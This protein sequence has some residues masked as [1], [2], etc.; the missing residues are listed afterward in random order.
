MADGDQSDGEVVTILSGDTYRVAFSSGPR[1]GTTWVVRDA[2]IDT[3]E[4]TGA[5]G[6]EGQGAVVRVQELIAPDARQVRVTEKGLDQ[7]GRIVAQVE[8][9]PSG[10]NI[11]VVLK[12]EGWG[13]GSDDTI[14]GDT[15]FMSFD[16]RRVGDGF[17]GD[18]VV[19]LTQ[20]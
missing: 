5:L 2:G 18:L 17:G 8:T 7:F 13:P 1:A 12:S 19:D 16:P 4:R 6:F 3:A 20:P 9:I 15:L 10:T 14:V 11:S